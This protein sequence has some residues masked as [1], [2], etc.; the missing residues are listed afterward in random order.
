MVQSL[1]SNK[2]LKCLFT[3]GDWLFWELKERK[4]KYSH[5]NYPKGYTRE[6]DQ[7]FCK[8]CKFSTINEKYW[9]DGNAIS[10]M[11]VHILENHEK[12]MIENDED[13]HP[14]YQTW[15]K[16]Y[17]PEQHFKKYGY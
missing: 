12:E 6:H 16:Q 2:N 10:S 13:V 9:N 11:F 1:S 5:Y 17:D 4:K 8:R 7:Y 15:S 14:R 3:N